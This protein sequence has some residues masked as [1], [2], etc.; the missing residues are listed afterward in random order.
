MDDAGAPPVLIGAAWCL[1]AGHTGGM[2]LKAL[3]AVLRLRLQ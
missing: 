2:E 1:P 3:K